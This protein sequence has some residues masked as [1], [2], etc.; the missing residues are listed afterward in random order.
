MERL[1]PELIQVILIISKSLAVAFIGYA[2]VIAG[3][4]IGGRISGYPGRG[5]EIHELVMKTL[6]KGKNNRRKK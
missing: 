1:S 6:F 4:E 3:I 2:S 5:I